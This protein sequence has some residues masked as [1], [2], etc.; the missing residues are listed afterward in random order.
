PGLMNRIAGALAICGAS[1]EG[2]RIFT[3]A[4][5]MALD[6]FYIVDPNG[7]AFD[8]PHKLAQLAATVEQTLAGRLRPLQELKKLASPLPSRLEVFTVTPRVLID[9][10]AS[11]RHTVIEVNGRDRPGL[12][13]RLTWALT[14]QNLIIDSAKIATYG[15]RAIDVFYVHDALGGKVEAEPK[16]KR[17]RTALL[18]ALD[19]GLCRAEGVPP[20]PAPAKLPS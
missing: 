6:I 20:K 8:R 11:R 17:I 15:E 1:V 13:Y 5:G 19:A 3:L 7:G 4:D 10:K 14:R 9:N 18:E 12:L 16:L 2:A